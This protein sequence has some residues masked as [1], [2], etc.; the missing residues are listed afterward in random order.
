MTNLAQ[1]RV[2]IA[3]RRVIRLLRANG[4]HTSSADAVLEGRPHNHVPSTLGLRATR[5]MNQSRNL[6]NTIALVLI[7]RGIDR[8]CVL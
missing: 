5:T 6:L 7:W 3:Q 4:A 2:K 1:K 8:R